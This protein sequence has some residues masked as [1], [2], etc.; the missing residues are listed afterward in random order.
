VSDIV[1]SALTGVLQSPGQF[2]YQGPEAFR[3]FLIR[4]VENKIANK[5]RYWQAHK[6]DGVEPVSD[7]DGRPDPLAHSPS[8][9]LALRESA[10][11]MQG[12]LEKLSEHER[13]LFTMRRIAQL[14]IRVIAEELQLAEHTVRRDLGRIMTK[15]SRDLGMDGH[16]P[17]GTQPR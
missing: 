6:R 16:E 2:T 8:D 13:R 11:R 1:Q 17:N 12:A 3:A 7:L 5:R 4:A 14:P 15:L 10:L 9:V